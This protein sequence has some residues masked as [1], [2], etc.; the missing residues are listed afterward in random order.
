MEPQSPVTIDS[1]VAAAD[2]EKAAK[3]IDRSAEAETI[4]AQAAQYLAERK[5]ADAR[6]ALE[7]ADALL[8]SPANG[9][10][11]EPT[12]GPNF[13]E[14]VR[15][16]LQ[17][18]SAS[19]QTQETDE[20]KVVLTPA[21]K[22]ADIVG[23]Y[24]KIAVGAGL[25]PGGLLN[26]AAILAVQVTMVWKIA[27]AFDQREGKDRIRGSI[28]SLI[29]SMLP[30][31]IGHG[32]GVAVTAIPAVMAGTALYFVLTPVLAYALTIAVGNAFIMHFESGGTLLSFD[33]KAFREHFVKDF[34]AAGGTLK[35][36]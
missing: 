17:K 29:G 21:E 10:A 13:F 15:A 9:P 5:F 28:L 22:S 19:G 31:S 1:N 14:R 35:T 3:A 12:N 23:L 36:A 27:D 34:Q 20:N 2:A 33:P 25:L 32:L 11:A 6:K 26:F 30:T 18:K 7:E 24:S 4:R 16:R 8:T